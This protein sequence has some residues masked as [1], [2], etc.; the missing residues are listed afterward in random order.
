MPMV[1]V[2]SAPVSN[3]T[4][5]TRAA[6]AGLAATVSLGCL[7]P[8][9]CIVEDGQIV[10]DSP[11][12]L[13]I[14]SAEYAK[15]LVSLSRPVA[16]VVHDSRTKTA[17]T[18]W[19]CHAEAR[20]KTPYFGCDRLTLTFTDEE[21]TLEHFRLIIGQA[22]SADKRMSYA[23]CRET[24]GKIVADMEGSLG[25]TMRRTSDSRS[26]EE[27]QE[28]VRE[29]LEEYSR[30]KDECYGFIQNYVCFVGGKTSKGVPVDYR[31]YGMINWRG[32][33][34]IHVECARHQEYLFPS[35]KTGNITPARKNAMVGTLQESHGGATCPLE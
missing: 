2:S 9:R 27:D 12:D 34:E 25:V 10:V 28:R 3:V 35:C 8:S 20:L 32:R 31:V 19:H 16:R 21:K 24:M 7:G 1:Y 4:V 33:C 13:E 14:G 22:S 11:F 26:E 5:G 23:E 18:N 6:F 30:R 17:T 15:A 29:V